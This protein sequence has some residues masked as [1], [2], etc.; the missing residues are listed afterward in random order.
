MREKLYNIFNKIYGIT[1]TIAFFTGIVPLILFI[2][3]LI[4]GGSTGEAIA[5]FL[6][7]HAYTWIIALASVSVIMGLI[8]MYMKKEKGLSTDKK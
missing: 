4:I 5:V 3:A 6:Y 1:M 8:A 2:M 7:K